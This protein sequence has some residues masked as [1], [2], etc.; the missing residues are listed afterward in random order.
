MYTCHFCHS[1]ISEAFVGTTNEGK[2]CSCFK[3]FIQTLKP[4]RFDDEYVHYPLF[5]IRNI[6]LEDSVVFYD[7]DGQELARVYL[8]SYQE[9]LLSYLKEEIADK[10]TLA[11]EK[12]KLVIEPFDL[13][14]KE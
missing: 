7:I 2:V 8:E 5:G 11:T 1:N 10:I 6:Q 9:G 13:Q 14:L 3:C 4:F 12:I